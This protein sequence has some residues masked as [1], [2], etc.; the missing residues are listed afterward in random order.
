[1]NKEHKINMGT[2]NFGMQFF[3]QPYRCLLLFLL[4]GC[5]YFVVVFDSAAL[6]RSDEKLVL[7]KT[8]L[9]IYIQFVFGAVGNT[10]Y[11]RVV[12]VLYDLGRLATGVLF[13]IDKSCK[14]C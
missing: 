10:M 2:S 13:F 7:E 4:F 11:M 9:Y 14:I 5:F 8:M 12:V 6:I 3:Q 1:M